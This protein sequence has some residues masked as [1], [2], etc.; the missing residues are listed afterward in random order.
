MN[1]IVFP[2]SEFKNKGYFCSEI[3]ELET[4]FK[5]DIVFINNDTDPKLLENIKKDGVIIYERL[6]DKN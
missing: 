5:I 6:L 4:L 3:H 2:L 1:I